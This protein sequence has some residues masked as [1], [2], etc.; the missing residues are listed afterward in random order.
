MKYETLKLA[1]QNKIAHVSFNRPRQSNAL[2]EQGWDEVQHVFEACSENP[3]VR[4]IVLSGEGKHFCA[5]MD[6]S[7][8]ANLQQIW[9]GDCEGRMRERFRKSV[10]RFQAP[11]NAIDHCRKPVLAAIHGACVGG[12]VDLVTACDMRYTTE[13]AFFSIAE[14]DIGMVADIGTLQRLPKLIGDG[15]VR[16]MAYT[17]RRVF[18]PEAEKIGLSNRNFVDKETM[19]VEVMKIAAMI[20]SKSPLSIRGTKEI[21][22]Y[23]RDHSVADG[24]NYVAAWNAGMFYSDDLRKALQAKM[25]KQQAEFID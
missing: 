1:I 7:V 20:A 13:G 2:N 16:E 23:A 17:G 9:Q 18:G 12:G 19:L 21:I 3:E 15:M 8:F 11:I 6:L 10:I 5:G 14:I 25:M 22:R 4:V 24:L